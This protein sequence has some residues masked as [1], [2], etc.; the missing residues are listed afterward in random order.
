MI[1]V[2]L[3]ILLSIFVL[4]AACAAPT[5]P[6]SLPTLAVLPTLA[7][8]LTLTPTATTPPPTPTPTPTLTA[9]PTL[10]E[11]PSHTPTPSLTPT[12]TFTPTPVYA[13]L[14]T[15]VAA[16]QSPMSGEFVSGFER[17]VYTFDGRAGEWVTLAMRAD[18]PALD[19]MVGLY[20]GRGVALA[21][22]DDSGGGRS[23][24]V[25]AVQLPADGVYIVQAVGGGFGLYTLTLTRSGVAP[26]IAPI[27]PS[28]TPLPPV[29][30]V[31]PAPASG[32]TLRDHVPMMGVLAPRGVS[33]YFINAQIGD[34][35]TI[36]A[37][38][39]APSA[40]LRVDVFNPA[41]EIVISLNASESAASG[42]TL[43]PA[44]GVIE[45]G[46]YTVI[47]RDEARV[48]G[49]YT[50]SYGWGSSHSDVL[51]GVAMPDTALRGNVERRGLR[52]V[53]SMYLNAGDRV[54]LQVTPDN[55]LFAASYRLIAPDG[56]LIA[57][58][59]TTPDGAP[60]NDIPIVTSG[61]HRIHIEGTFAR[62]FGS[63]TLTW[64][65]VERGTAPTPAPL[66]FPVL[67]AEDVILAGTSPL[68]PF[69]GRTGERV[70]VR[71]IGVDG[72]DPV[73][74]LL[75]PSGALVA[76]SD[77][78]DGLNALIEAALPADGTYLVQVSGYAGMG[79][80]ARITVE[81]VEDQRAR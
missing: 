48:G 54:G 61:W 45:A 29:G 16:L 55:A 22:D 5:P 14:G 11:T 74:L 80:A 32:R 47:V 58:T 21:A 44:L 57:A 12:N 6:P 36:G 49:A 28:A 51:R 13:H 43:I 10:T 38:A 71:V 52:D 39:A 8:T 78:A 77:D 25:R 72:F 3:L 23:A 31:T 15:F 59:V 63:Y 1:R 41:G 73:A 17:H 27:P 19:P 30:S 79:G 35:L 46:D 65:Y 56:G 70:R 42:D 75:D 67:A 50:I 37:R 4:T 33:R 64:R 7:P 68:Y 24:L 53:W 40:N 9:S 60:L 69:Q 62:T 66:V 26:I 76:Q 18:D 20:D 81:R 34:F 2:P